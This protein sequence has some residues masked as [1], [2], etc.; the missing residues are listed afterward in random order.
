MLKFGWYAQALQ[1]ASYITGISALRWMGERVTGF[2]KIV[3]KYE[4]ESE[5]EPVSTIVLPTNKALILLE[6]HETHER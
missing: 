2:I 5:T 1:V 4:A 6:F 3:Q